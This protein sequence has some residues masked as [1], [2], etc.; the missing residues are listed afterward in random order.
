M[1][2]NVEPNFR[3]TYTHSVVFFGWV[4]IF[5]SSSCLDRIHR[6]VVFFLV[7]PI[8][9]H[10]L[11]RYTHTHTWPKKSCVTIVRN[12]RKCWTSST[13]TQYKHI[14]TQ[15]LMAR[16]WTTSLW[17]FGRFSISAQTYTYYTLYRTYMSKCVLLF[18]FYYY[19]YYSIRR[20]R[21]STTS[22]ERKSSSYSESESKK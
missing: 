17:I 6:L 12:L 4:A 2:F 7:V 16:H 21:V 14:R 19:T 9:R 20:H 8:L 3:T 11:T 18:L 10:I 13:Y 5:S 15:T 22:D 1:L